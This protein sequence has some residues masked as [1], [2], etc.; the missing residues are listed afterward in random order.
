VIAPQSDL[1]IV[2][3]TAPDIGTARTLARWVLERRLAACVNLLPE[4]E[5]H[6]WWQGKLDRG[7]EVLMLIKT[8]AA[9]IPTLEQAILERHPYD[10]AEFVVLSASGVT[11]KYW[12][13][14]QESVSQ[15]A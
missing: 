10:T 1:Q 5:S 15:N 3:V 13:W 8:T 2:L 4:I 14:V 9:Q 12:R 11:D 6:Y 7:T